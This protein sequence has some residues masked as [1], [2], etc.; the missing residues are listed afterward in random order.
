MLG[1]GSAAV[2]Q[3]YNT[4]FIVKSAQSM[5][6]VDA[7]G[8]N[9]ILSQMRHAG[10]DLARLHHLFITHAHTDHILGAVWIV[11]MVIQLMKNGKHDGT[12]TV[13]SHDKALAVLSYI[14]QMT[15]PA[16][17]KPLIA[18]QVEMREVTDG[19]CIDM[20][21]IKLQCFDIFSTKEKQ[22]GFAMQ[23]PSGG[24]LVCLGDEPYNE[25][26]RQY[27]ENAKWLMSE[28]FCLY[29]DRET[30]KPY[31]KHHS[32]V[33]DAASV[34]DALNVENLILYHTED[35]T[36]STRK[37]NYAAEAAQ[38]FNGNVFVPDDLETIEIA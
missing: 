2:T 26:C 16:S 14:C 20:E 11:R 29:K 30:F 12:F 17:Y 19:E 21:G 37:C 18:T 10:I 38:H 32:T 24:K 5:F 15:L 4:C 34:A 36:L 35:A 31:E 33:L 25:R 7:G 27:A 9:G 3:C 6:M 1:T 13:Y 8:G 23:L 28:A 22:F